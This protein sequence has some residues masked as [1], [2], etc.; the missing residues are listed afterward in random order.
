MKRK[1]PAAEFFRILSG[2]QLACSLF[3]L[4]CLGQDVDMLRDFYYQDDRRVSI[5]NL[6][7]LESFSE[8]E[9]TNRQVKL[10]AAMK[11]YNEDR[12]SSF[13][14]KAVDEQIKLIQIQTTL[15]RDLGHSFMNLSVSETILRCILLNHTNRALKIKGDLRVDDKR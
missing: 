14:A 13:E 2:K 15:E 1:L 3:E 8:I 7:L 10:K 11:L 5:A 4:Y 9:V 12:T 6:M